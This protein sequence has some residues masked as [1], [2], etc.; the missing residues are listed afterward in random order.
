MPNFRVRRTLAAALLALP[1]AAVPLAAQAADSYPSRPIRL[2]VPFAAGSG[3]DAVARITAKELGDALG[4][5][6]VVDNR[7]GANGAIAAELVAQAAPDG[8]TLFMTTNTTHSANPSLMKKLPYDPIKDFTPVARMG[9]LP[10]MLVINPKLPVKTVGELIAYAKAHP[11]MSYASGNSTGIVSGATLGRMAN[12]DLLHVPY[13]STPPAMTD[14][15]AGQVPMMFVDVAAGIANVKA[16]KMRAL[17]VTTAQR[18][19]LLPDLP[20]IA[21]TPELKGFDITSWNGVFAPAKTP[22]PIVERLNR[23]L[24]KIA[25]SKEVAPKFEALG[26]EAFGQT[27]QQFTA[28]VGSEL[29]K[30]NKLVKD[31]G[32]QPE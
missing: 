9:N 12:I 26:F 21:D 28:F 18:S 15:I 20:P 10:F 29:V 16:G 11:G 17:A 22:Q 30:W 27:P 2:V 25:S 14:V 19:R 5:N 32:I 7:P 6:V 1:M 3:T 31:A 13:K 24:S 8:Y 23:E 4:Q